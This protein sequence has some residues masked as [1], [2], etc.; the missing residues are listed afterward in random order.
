MK[1]TFKKALAAVSAA[2]VVA[3]SAAVFTAVPADAIGGLAIAGVTVT[4]DELKA[5]NYLVTVPVTINGNSDGWDAL[6]F[7]MSWNTSEITYSSNTRGGLLGDAYINQNIEISGSG[8]QLTPDGAGAWIAYASTPSATGPSYVVGDGTIINVIFKV[9]ENAQPGD[10]YYIDSPA[11]SFDGASTPL[12]QHSP[13]ASTAPASQGYI[14]IEGV[15]TTTT[16]ATTTTTTTTTT[17]ATTTTTTTTKATTTTTTTTAK[18]TTTTTT[19]TTTAKP[20]T[21]TAKMTTTTTTTTKVSGTSDTKDTGNTSATNV[22]GGTGVTKTTTTKKAAQ[23][24]TKKNTGST[25]SPK[26]GSMIPVAGAVAAIAVIG[27]VALVSKKRK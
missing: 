13:D 23:Q 5:N 19:T 18:P 8:L 25:S 12:V 9:N 11:V 7:G 20:T 21:T 14:Q 24:T 1:S 22:T 3:T 4:M 2:A 17:K 26:T 16:E 6:A 15:Q 27:G 10:I